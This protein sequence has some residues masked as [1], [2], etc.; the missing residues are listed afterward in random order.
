MQNESSSEPLGSR[1]ALSLCFAAPWHQSFSQMSKSMA[2]F[3]AKKKKEKILS[4]FCIANEN[5]NVLHF[6]ACLQPLLLPRCVWYRSAL[7]LAM[8]SKYVRVAG[9]VLL[10]LPLRKRALGGNTE[11]EPEPQTPALYYP[12]TC[13]P[14]RL[15]T[16]QLRVRKA[17]GKQVFLCKSD[18]TSELKSYVVPTACCSEP[19]AGSVG[20]I[21]WALLLLTSTHGSSLPYLQ[22]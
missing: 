5:A 22:H 9:G 18:A 7:P 11:E 1:P 17:G 6:Q 3:T 14:W 21:C 10:A 16:D 15:K 12:S 20:L 13:R 19:V 4:V 8:R 2:S